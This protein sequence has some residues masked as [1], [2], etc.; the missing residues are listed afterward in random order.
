MQRDVDTY[1]AQPTDEMEVITINNIETS[2]E[3]I[4]HVEPEKE[5]IVSDQPDRPSEEARWEAMMK[6]M[7]EQFGQVKEDNRTLREDSQKN[8]E[9]LQE[10]G[11]KSHKK[12]ND[13]MNKNMEALQEEGRKSREENQ[14]NIELLNKNIESLKEDLNKRIDSTH[15]LSLIHI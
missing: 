15:K 12:L 7:M 11:K 9:A 2:T 6:I 10:D 4:P 8:M 13:L 14:R 1:E 3:E 5:L